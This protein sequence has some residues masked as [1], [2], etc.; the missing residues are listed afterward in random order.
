MGTNSPPSAQ[1]SEPDTI[2]AGTMS[3]N[4]AKAATETTET[5]EITANGAANPAG[6]ANGASST[7]ESAADDGTRKKP[8]SSP[9]REEL[10]RLY[11]VRP[12][13][14][15]FADEAVRLIVAESGVTAAA[16]FTY[17]ARNNQV[18]ALT[19]RG[20]DDEGAN[21]VRRNVGRLWD[22]PLRSIRNR[23]I[24]V[25]DSAHENPFV[26]ADIKAIGENNL[27]IASIPF[28]HQNTP[29]GV[30]VLFSVE[31]DGFPDDALRSVSQGLRVF[32]AA[33]KELPKTAAVAANIDDA[34]NG[35]VGTDQ[36]NLLRGLAALKS[37]LVRLTGALEESERSRAS[38]VAER[39]TAQ[40]FLKAAQQ[41]SERAEQE[42]DELRAKQKRIP[43][44][45]KEGRELEQRLN[46]AIE[47]AEKAKT[48][49]S[50]LESTLEEK[51]LDNEAKA[52][53]LAELQAR[54]TELERELQR[55]GEL[56]ERHEQSAVQLNEQLGRLDAIKADAEKLRIELEEATAARART[57]ERVA[58][59]EVA[60]A[61]AESERQE[62][63]DELNSSKT[64]LDT[65]KKERE[66][67][68]TD[69][70]K[71]WGKLEEIE[72]Q[73][74]SL[75]RER[76][77]LKATT[78][79]NEQR[80]QELESLREV[81]ETEKREKAAALDQLSNQVETLS[82]QRVQLH[83][84]LERIRGESGQT[85]S[86][87]REQLEKTD[88]DRTGLSEQIAALKRVEDE[89]DRLLSRVDEL[90]GDANSTRQKNQRLEVELDDLKKQAERL[91]IE[92]GALEMRIEV[93]AEGEQV[94]AR[95]KSEE[96]AR[97]T[98]EADTIRKELE[99]REQ[100]LQSKEEE[101]NTQLSATQ[102]EAESAL[103]SVRQ[104]LTQVNE[105]K[106]KLEADLNAAKEDESVR[107]EL[108]ATAES[109]QNKLSEQ[110][111]TLSEERDRLDQDLQQT[112]TDLEASTQKSTE[113]AARVA[114]LE[115]SLR[116][117]KDGDLK[118]LRSQLESTTTSRAEL[119]ES[120][121]AAEERHSLEI[122]DLQDRLS[123]LQQERDQLTQNL[124]EKEQ[125]LQSAEHGLTTLELDDEVDDD[126]AL[127]I[128]RSGVP[129]DDDIEPEPAAQAAAAAP[130]EEIVL[131]DS[132]ESIQAAMQKLVS[133]GHSV[134]SL[135]PSPESVTELALTS[136]ACAAINLAAP[137]AWPTLRKMRNGSGIPHTPMIGYALGENAD[138]GFWLGP[139]DFAT[140]PIE[141]ADLNQMLAAM[142]PNLRRV[143]A[144]SH[145]FDIM[146]SVRG[147][148]TAARVSTAVV[149]D[150]RQVLDLVPTV[151]PQAA[152]L[153]MSPNCTDVFRAVAG[154][155]SQEETRDIPILFLLDEEAQ[156]REE[157]FVTAGIRMLSGR[158]TLVPDELANSLA[159]ALDT[160]QPSA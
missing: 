47:L 58:E 86:E 27:T 93:L 9:L 49:V 90:E 41:R 96:V 42:L 99:V 22:I 79:S 44:L 16:I 102:T 100:T 140:V 6:A 48:R 31:P 15:T 92:K 152:V 35:T 125:L 38:E 39:V 87:L 20:F 141:E 119:E 97:L 34:P 50:E 122:I 131:L 25:I 147:H 7:A 40:S 157:S 71:S 72:E 109:E 69:A 136:F 127:E 52:R 24:N 112:R 120:L 82:A 68:Y 55:A 84:E 143:I 149:F 85:I 118:E 126:L 53:E 155:R 32:A 91:D 80:I 134:T 36:P 1:A 142:V 70:L 159:S 17:A 19:T 13:L 3:S 98:A 145:D 138:K 113:T 62:L 11:S 67:L 150:G 21:A 88:R 12:S 83:E 60:L 5:P 61:T 153:H 66:S 139:V 116:A 64:A 128:D 45:E 33:I 46:N 117:L 75:V 135:N 107:D 151:K 156:P 14:D 137:T 59:L 154:L 37:E 26:P 121:A 74:A 43:E 123:Q 8:A 111:R 95:E 129:D 114:E 28:Y 56:A 73:R 78:E 4:E 130:S 18:T 63:S 144:M 77:S 160:F 94:L 29:M 148:L 89:R 115:E 158:G 101:F 132:E 146:E 110:V 108:L 76:E 57:E 81:L 104:E 23:R 54:R 10:H 65:T 2:P 105:L 103:E 124:E 30:A 106:T 133:I 51:T